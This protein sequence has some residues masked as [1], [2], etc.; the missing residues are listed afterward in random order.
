MKRI[1][2]T[3]AGGPAASNFINSLSYRNNCRKI[4]YNFYFFSKAGLNMPYFYMKSA[5]GEKLPKLRK[6]DSLSKNLY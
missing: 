3:G 1:I 4:F 6:Y 5:F 2:V